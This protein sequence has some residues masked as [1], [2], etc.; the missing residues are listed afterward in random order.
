[1][2]RIVISYRRDDASAHAGRIYDRLRTEF[3]SDQV[4]MDI[5]AIEPGVDFVEAIEDAIGTADVLIAVIG[6]RWVTIADE[7]GQPRIKNPTDFVR[8]EL[9]TALERNIRVIPVLVDGATMPTIDNLPEDLAGLVRRNAIDISHARFHADAQRL[10]ISVRRIL[11]QEDESQI[12]AAPEEQRSAVPQEDLPAPT[13]D[14]ARSATSRVRW[15]RRILIGG[16]TLVAI[17]AIVA[18]YVAYGFLTLPPEPSTF[19]RLAWSPD[20]QHIAF[21]GLTPMGKT[22]LYSLATDGSGWEKLE[23]DASTPVTWSPGGEWITF[24]RALHYVAMKMGGDESRVLPGDAIF[25]G[26]LVWSS[27]GRKAAYWTRDIGDDIYHLRVFDFAD[28]G[29]HTAHRARALGSGRDHGIAWSPDDSL[30]AVVVGNDGQ[31]ELAVV[32]A[33]TGEARGVF[34][35][36]QIAIEYPCWSKDGEWIVFSATS[37]RME[38]AEQAIFRIRPD[39]TDLIRL[40]DENLNAAGPRI[41]PDGLVVAATIASSAW[42]SR[43]LFVMNLDGSGQPRPISPDTL[44]VYPESLSWSPDGRRLA[45][46]TLTDTG[47]LFGRYRST[48]AVANSDGRDF[49]VLLR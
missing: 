36:S 38:S 35:G 47:R 22:H 29:L 46:V 34:R 28:H 18:A 12:P 3:G 19:G 1:M 17:I 40:T 41:S 25:G 30:I 21:S 26:S 45:F 20:G 23:S 11:D 27:D 6:R 42:G 43:Q 9:A 16:V 44:S 39:G 31:D 24:E 32:H 7:E 37:S 10:A 49:K 15:K 5:D 4:F 8:L 33:V 13:P 48:V 2:A 14:V